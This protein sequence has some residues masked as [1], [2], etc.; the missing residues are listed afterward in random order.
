MDIYVAKED[1]N[2]KN[3]DCEE[4]E[5]YTSV[6]GAIDDVTLNVP[7]DEE[8]VLHIAPGFYKERVEIKRNNITILGDTENPSDI[9]ISMDYCAVQILEDTGEKR[10]TFRSYTFLI[11]ADNVT[12]KDITIE[13]SA[14][15]SSIYEQAVAVY[16][17]GDNLTFENVRMLGHQDTLFTAPLPPKAVQP[18]GLRGPGEFKERRLGK[19]SYVNC[20]ICGD[21]D[22]I[23]GGAMAIFENCVIE[24]LAQTID[25]VGYCTAASTPEGA[26]YGYIFKK[27]RFIADSKV[28]E[29]SVYLG[30]PWREYAQSEFIDCEFGKHINKAYFDEWSGR[31]A[32]GKVKYSVH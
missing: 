22:F 3:V 13:N 12:V 18:N 9:F 11:M 20:Y 7:D 28:P 14:G 5:Y 19:Q 31:I 15:D 25:N 30:R 23:F 10:G 2:F 1:Y 4:L 29:G 26:E 27:C 24:S 17:D 6:Q 16:A 32:A 8:I 21:I